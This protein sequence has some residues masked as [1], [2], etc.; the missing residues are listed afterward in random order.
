MLRREILAWRLG[1]LTDIR[2]RSER[3]EPRVEADMVLI[4]DRRLDVL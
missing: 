3:A 4:A 1:G 2:G